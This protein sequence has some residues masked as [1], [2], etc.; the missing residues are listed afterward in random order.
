MVRWYG[1]IYNGKIY[2]KKENLRV[3]LQ[4][5]Q[6]TLDSEFEGNDSKEINH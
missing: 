4:I 5:T 3:E 6:S 1:K 2:K